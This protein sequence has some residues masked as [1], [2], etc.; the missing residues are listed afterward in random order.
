VPAPTIRPPT[1]AT[2]TSPWDFP[3]D[4]AIALELIEVERRKVTAGGV[5]AANLPQFFKNARRSSF[6]SSSD[7]RLT[8]SSHRE[9]R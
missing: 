7:T 3:P 6:G 2:G 9:P 5:S 1:A 8:S 4:A